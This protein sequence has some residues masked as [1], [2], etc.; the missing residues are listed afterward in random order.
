[1]DGFGGHRSVRSTCCLWLV[2]LKIT[3]DMCAVS[4]RDR[5]KNTNACLHNKIFAIK[6]CAKLRELEWQV[7]FGLQH[8]GCRRVG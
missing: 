5:R 8:T 6:P 7:E 1:M 4:A 3:V 2:R